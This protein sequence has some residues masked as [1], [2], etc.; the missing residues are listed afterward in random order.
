MF[1]RFNIIEQNNTE[2]HGDFKQ[3]LKEVK[4]Q[5]VKT[6]REV[7]D[8]QSEVTELRHDVGEVRDKVEA[9]TNDLNSHK[10][11]MER[12]FNDLLAK[13]EAKSSTVRVQVRHLSAAQQC[14]VEDKFES[15][16]KETQAL[17]TIFVIGKVPG[18]RP[19]VSL[20][21][22]LQRHFVQLGAK[23]IPTA[24]KTRTCRFSVPEEKVNSTRD[25]IR[26]YN[27]AICDL[28]YWIVQDAP[29]ALRKLNSNTFTF[30]KFAKDCFQPLRRF[31]FEAEGGYVLVDDVPFLPVY[32][33]S[34]KKAKWKALA[35]LLTELVADGLERDWLDAAS[36]PLT[37]LDKFV[38]Q[39]CSVIQQDS[40]PAE[41]MEL[42]NKDE[43]NEEVND[44][45]LK[46]DQA[47]SGGG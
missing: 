44:D 20:M 38:E 12:R 29:P 43:F 17:K 36:T 39:W 37:I 7:D 23:L 2:R 33:V 45:F 10:A 42:G 11:E 35:T 14:S 30:F 24:G 32:M 21:T 13:F 22:L 19:T 41:E 31:R 46:E 27:L 26:H 28:G 1:E 9:V 6:C 47:A 8:L 40:S 3:E 4:E 18:A 34:S 16:L 25:V 15:L 5:Q